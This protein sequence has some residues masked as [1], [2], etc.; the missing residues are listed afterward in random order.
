MIFLNHFFDALFYIMSKD[1][2]MWFF[3][4]GSAIWLLYFAF[5]FL[6]VAR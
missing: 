1:Y 4:L 2:G 5:R 3:V 6:C